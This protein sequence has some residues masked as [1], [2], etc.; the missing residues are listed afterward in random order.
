MPGIPP[1]SRSKGVSRSFYLSLRLLPAPM[2]NAASIGYLLARASDTIA[3]SAGASP[4]DRLAALR[5]YS[6]AVGGSIAAFPCPADLISGIPD[7]RERALLEELPGLL[8]SLALLP[9][10]ERD[11]V[12]GVVATIIGG[13]ELDLIRFGNATAAHPVALSDGAALTDYT[14]RV[15]GCVGEF[16]TKLGFLT[17]GERFSGAAPEMLLPLAR[18]YGT[19]L[20][21]VNILRDLPRDLAAGRCY[22][23][24]ANPLDKDR[25]LDSHRVWH[26]KARAAVAQGL[27][28]A[29]SL[30][31]RRQ[32][33]ASVLP[34][35][36]A[37]ETLDLL[38]NA[39][40]KTL[41]SRV[42]VP[43]RRIYPLLARAFFK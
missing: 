31:S 25:L 19:G 39:D 3:D 9:A 13:Q 33:A 12:R 20:Q 36:I 35:L 4:A 2:R 8:E 7:P 30:R 29:D 14:W 40:W 24:V 43:R 27:A 26:A 22:L 15:A 6:R 17:L 32:R 34:A 10:A 41:E 11:L 38:E 21:L 1:V 42:K 28:Y 23:P 16:W 37:E 5:D 18:D